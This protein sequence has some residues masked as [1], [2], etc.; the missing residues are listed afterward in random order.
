M[1][2]AAEN[3]AS[4]TLKNII[5]SF[6][7]IKATR[8]ITKWVFIPQWENAGAAEAVD[9]TSH[10]SGISVE[11]PITGAFDFPDVGDV[12]LGFP[13]I[14]PGAIAQAAQVE[15]SVD[16]LEKARNGTAYIYLWGWT[17][18]N[19]ID[20][21]SLRRRTEFCVKIDVEG[22]LRSE[23][24]QFRFSEQ[25]WHNGIDDCC[26]RNPRPYFGNRCFKFLDTAHIDS[27]I[28]GGTVIVSSLSHFRSLEETGCWGAIADDLEASSL[29]TVKRGLIVTQNSPELEVVNNAGIGLGMVKSSPTYPAVEA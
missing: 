4:I 11:R 26:L 8:T 2:G 6:R 12:A 20:V 7:G 17:D 10:T 25:P 3:S 28:F 16:L 29:L 13:P 19:D 18:Y 21:E 5:P 27:V 22:D 14:A 23:D 1:P 9:R 15:L 24:C